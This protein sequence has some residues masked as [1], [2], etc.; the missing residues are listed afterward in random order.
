[1]LIIGSVLAAL[2]ASSRDMVGSKLKLEWLGVREKSCTDKVES[3][4]QG[5]GRG[6]PGGARID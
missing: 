2:T 3:R 6:G 4:S 5:L 1:M